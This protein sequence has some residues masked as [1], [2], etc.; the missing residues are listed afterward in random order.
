MS[1]DASLRDSDVFPFLLGR[2]HAVKE[3]V[4]IYHTIFQFHEKEQSSSSSS[5]HACN[6]SMWK[7]ASCTIT[8]ELEPR[9][10][11]LVFVLFVF[12]VGDMDP[13]LHQYHY[14]WHSVV[15]LLNSVRTE[16]SNRTVFVLSRG[17]GRTVQDF[18]WS[19]RLPD[20]ARLQMAIQTCP[21]HDHD[22]ATIHLDA[23]L[24]F[25]YISPGPALERLALLLWTL[26]GSVVSLSLAYRFASLLCTVRR[27]ALVLFPGLQGSC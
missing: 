25:G 27:D 8:L 4:T 22:V 21:L 14:G 2:K 15:I 7:H 26:P 6:S 9:P 24:F 18:K 16:S 19:S 3:E 17:N 1:K 12:F 13:P 5:L 11:P 10:L 23:F 20:C